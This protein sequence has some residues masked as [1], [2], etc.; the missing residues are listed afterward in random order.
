[1]R[2]HLLAVMFFGSLIVAISGI[3]FTAAAQGQYG[4]TIT[5]ALGSEPSTM[6]L[7]EATR[8][9]EQAVLNLVHEPLFIMNKELLPEPLLVDS[10]E[11]SADGLTWT[12]V[13]KQGIEFHDGTSLNAEA[14]AFSINRHLTAAHAYMLGSL[15]EAVAEDEYTVVF[16]FDESYPELLSYLANYWIGMVSPQA[17]EELGEDY[18]VKGFVGTGPFVFKEWISGDKIILEK[19]PNYTHGPSFLSNQGPAY[20]DE[21]VFRFIVEPFTLIAELE[22]GD[23]DCTTYIPEDAY[24]QIADNS[25]LGLATKPA[26][27]TIHLAINTSADNAPYDDVRVREAIAHAVNRDAVIQAALFGVAAPLYSLTPP[28][29]LGYWEEGADLAYQYTNY[30]AQKSR[31]LLEEAGWVDTDGDGIREKNGEELDLVFFAFNIARYS[32]VAEVVQPMLA[33]VGFN[34]QIMILEPGDLYERVIRGEHDLLSTAWM[35]IGAAQDL[36]FPLCHSDS[37]GTKTS[38]F[39]FSTPELDAALDLSLSALD[40]AERVQAIY[41]AQEIVIEAAVC[42]PAA[43]PLDLFGYKTARI[44]GVDEY[45]EHPWA[46]ARDDAIKALLLYIE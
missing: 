33:E 14:V 9:P 38:W 31:S 35:G 25:T 20:V 43:S 8:S 45:M 26:P 41:K 2:K 29:A 1:M 32:R 27:S 23:V 19:N 46:F 34:V 40:D 12:F 11:S 22:E 42:A 13:I 44:G 4:G 24:D 15:N 6:N 7:F 10:W 30:D 3:V 16:N 37:L 18:G 17:V 28:G 36:L 21:W 39:L 5:E